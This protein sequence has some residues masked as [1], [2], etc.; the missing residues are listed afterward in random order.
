MSEMD[1]LQLSSS[2]Q[3][4][5]DTADDP[6]F[7]NATEQCSESQT[8]F[9]PIQHIPATVEMSGSTQS[10]LG[11]H[12]HIADGGV[13]KEEA[14]G[15]CLYTE[16]SRSEMGDTQQTEYEQ[17]PLST[18]DNLT[19]QVFQPVQQQLDRQM[20]GTENNMDL[21]SISNQNT[22]IPQRPGRG[23]KPYSCAQCQKRFNYFPE[24]ER[25]ERIHLGEKPFSCAQC[26]KQF[27]F[28][29][30]L[31]RHERVHTG[32]KPFCCVHCGKRFSLRC[33]LIRHERIHTG[34]KPFGCA[35]CGKRFVL[36][37]NLITHERIHTGNKPFVCVHCGKRFTQASNLR[38]HNR[39]HTG[40]RPHHCTL[41]GKSFTYLSGLKTHQKTHSKN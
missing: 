17:P 41:C 29:V 33:N 5:S 20:G 22:R 2:T 16:E 3:G 10:S 27:C 14:G 36:R 1:N 6:A 12:Q 37:A 35:Q 34:N 39:I 40:E 38:V 15:Q 11:K 25:H 18:N 19:S 23:E 8:I 32:S 9:S 28:R 13:V 30:N 7:A 24:L 4:D 21:I 31:M 26:G